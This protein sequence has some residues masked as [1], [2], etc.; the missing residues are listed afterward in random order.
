MQQMIA[1][2]L[3]VLLLILP[4]R[5][6]AQTLLDGVARDIRAEVADGRQWLDAVLP[7]APRAG[8][9]PRAL[10]E[11]AARLASI[12]QRLASYA[13]GVTD[14]GQLLGWQYSVCAAAANALYA[15]NQYAFG[16]A[17]RRSRG[18]QST[19]EQRTRVREF[20]ALVRALAGELGSG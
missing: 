5:T 10:A 17:M 12:N 11:Q 20:T 18:I 3:A 6:S 19:E 13:A 15:G 16:L 9:A 2:L 7:D 8:D 4:A 14:A 1:R